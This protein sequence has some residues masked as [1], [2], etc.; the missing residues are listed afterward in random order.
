MCRKKNFE[1]L[2]I[3]NEYVCWENENFQ[4]RKTR[5]LSADKDKKIEE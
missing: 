1:T 5:K 4:N 3:N 2:L